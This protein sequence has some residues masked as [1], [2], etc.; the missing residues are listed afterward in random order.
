MKIVILICALQVAPSD[1]TRDT[2]IDVTHG[3]RVA[4]EIECGK[5]GQAIPAGTAI[6]PRPGLEYPK[7]L[8]ERE[9]G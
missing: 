6:A 2:A 8:C 3:P 1:C 9:R 4:N 5:I 7:I